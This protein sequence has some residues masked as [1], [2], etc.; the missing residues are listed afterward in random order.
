MRS[1]IKIV[2]NQNSSFF[3][4][5]EFSTLTDACLKEFMDEIDKLLAN[6]APET[7][8]P[9]TPPPKAD[10]PARPQ[11]SLDDLL[12]QLDSPQ[13]ANFSAPLPDRLMDE[14]KADYEQQ[15]AQLELERQQQEQQKQKRLDQ[16]KAQRR[17]ELT[18]QAAQWLKALNPQSNEGKWF[19][20]FACNYESRLEAAIDYL[21][22]LKEVSPE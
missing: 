22:A 15:Q 14:V 2:V 10:V 18:E 11:G 13:S 19:E 6:L 16:L 4:K 3:K 7:Q 1:R 8:K 20:E 12:K 17:V 5:S 21:E 9:Q